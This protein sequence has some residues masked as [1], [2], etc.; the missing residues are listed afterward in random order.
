MFECSRISAA[1]VLTPTKQPHLASSVPQRSKHAHFFPP[2]VY[3]IY[4][5]VF[6]LSPL[7]ASVLAQSKWRV[8]IGLGEKRKKKKKGSIS[9]ALNAVE[10]ATAMIHR[11]ERWD[12]ST[13]DFPFAATSASSRKSCRLAEKHLSLLTSDKQD[14]EIYFAIKAACREPYR[15]C[16]GVKLL[17]RSDGLPTQ[18]ASDWIGRHRE[19]DAAHRRPSSAEIIRDFDSSSGARVGIF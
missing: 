14:A 7:L 12:F 5:F 11:C 8:C 17:Q 4:C 19:N 16:G 13:A 1:S 15:P 10:T 18:R 2:H 3:F 9:F 6:F